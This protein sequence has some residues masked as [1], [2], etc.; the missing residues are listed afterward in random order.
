ML[1]GATTIVRLEGALAHDTVLKIAE[2]HGFQVWPVDG[3]RSPTIETTTVSWA[4]GGSRS[5]G[6][7]VHGTGVPNPGQTDTHTPPES[8]RPHNTP[9]SSEK[10]GK[11]ACKRPARLLASPRY[12]LF[13]KLLG[14]LRCIHILWKTMWTCRE[15]LDE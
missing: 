10:V 15:A 8:H 7:L 3:H 2:S 14:E 1:L 4:C 13:H 9:K 5:L 12:R 11:S 6:R